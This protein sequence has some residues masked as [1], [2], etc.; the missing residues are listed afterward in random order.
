M[1]DLSDRLSVDLQPAMTAF[2]QTIVAAQKQGLTR[3]ALKQ[4]RDVQLATL[5]RQR[6]ILE[7]LALQGNEA[8]LPAAL[9]VLLQLSGSAERALLDGATPDRLG[10]GGTLACS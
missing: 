1:S 3:A 7:Q 9:E 5:K 10:G 8:A 4:Q 2:L 6:V